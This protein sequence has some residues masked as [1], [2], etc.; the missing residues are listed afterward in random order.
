MRFQRKIKELRIKNSLLQR[1]VAFAIGIDSAIY[2][3]LEKGD[4]LASEAQVHS[5]ADFYNVDY[6]E[7]RQLWIADKVYA[8]LED[9]NNA[10]DILSLVAED[11]VGYGK[12]ILTKKV[13]K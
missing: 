4:R 13:M 11:I 12:T 10:C 8:I 6:D 3:K 1:Q 9:E 7:L 2:C 5:L